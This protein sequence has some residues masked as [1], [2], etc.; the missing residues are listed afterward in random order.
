MSM[1]TVNKSD[2]KD[3]YGVAKSKRELA[4]DSG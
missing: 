4:C 1:L 3:G 2:W